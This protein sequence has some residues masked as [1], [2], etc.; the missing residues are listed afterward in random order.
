MGSYGGKEH[1]VFQSYLNIGH[2]QWA[3]HTVGLAPTGVCK[4]VGK[5]EAQWGRAWKHTQGSGLHPSTTKE[6][7]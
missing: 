7:Q 6:K 3:V 2:K 1:R 4:N 5:G